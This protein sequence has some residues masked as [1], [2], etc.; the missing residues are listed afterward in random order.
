MNKSESI[1]KL[2]AALAK[3]QAE[4]PVV[5]MDA[6]NPFLKYKYATL[7]AMIKTVRPILARHGF[8][9]VQLPINDGDS[10]GVDTVL[11]HESGEWVED[12]IVIP[13]EEQKGLS[14]AQISG[15]AIT[16]LRR[17][18]LASLLGLYADEDT[19]AAGEDGNE[20]PPRVL[21]QKP[22]PE[23]KTVVPATDHA[24]VKKAF[25]QVFA[26]AKSLGIEVETISGSATDEEIIA[27]TKK[28]ENKIKAANGSKVEA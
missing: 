3:A 23:I 15:V 24:K 9:V 1:T 6:K 5:E 20:L 18:S 22:A 12:A 19:D 27:A 17:Y 28:I 10:I 2:A 16:Y 8:S 11:L 26:Q 21:P 14:Q 13:L 25:S 7:G 4:M